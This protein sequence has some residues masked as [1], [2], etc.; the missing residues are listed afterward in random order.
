MESYSEAG[1]IQIT[2][3]VYELVKH[4]FDC[5][6]RGTIYVKGKGSMST[7]FLMGVKE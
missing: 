7:Y 3:E 6:A 2:G 1:T 5:K 4:E